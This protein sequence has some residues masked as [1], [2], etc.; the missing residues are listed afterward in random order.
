MFYQAH[1]NSELIKTYHENIQSWFPIVARI[2]LFELFTKADD[3][4][5]YL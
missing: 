1:R 2:I 3:E 4:I 5:L